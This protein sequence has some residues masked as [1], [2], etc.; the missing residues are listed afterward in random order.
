MEVWRVLEYVALVGLTAAGI[1]LA[2]RL[3][4]VPSA[5]HPGPI[6]AGN[7]RLEAEEAFSD[8]LAE[9][10]LAQISAAVTRHQ[11]RPALPAMDDLVPLGQHPG[12][13]SLGE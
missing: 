3:L 9:H 2:S 7:P 13:R 8:A 1:W 12:R 11:D 10:R 5:R 6:V 4:R